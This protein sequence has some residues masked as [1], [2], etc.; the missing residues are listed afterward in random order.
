M[1]V[2]MRARRI[3]RAGRWLVVVAVAT[4]ASC[5]VNHV[6]FRPRERAE[7]ESPDGHPAA[8]YVLG[9]AAHPL[10]EVRVWSRGATRDDA[11]GSIAVH[12]GFEVENHSSEPLAIDLASTRLT[13][14]RAGDAT[15]EPIGAPEFEGRPTTAPGEVGVLE[16]LFRLPESV[17][18]PDRIGSFDVAWSVRIAADEARHQVTPFRRVR[19]GPA[20]YGPAWH[21]PG[22][23]GPSRFGPSWYGPSWCGP[24]WYGGHWHAGYHHGCHP[25]A[26]VLWP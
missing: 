18:S 5:A 6:D 23:Y 11:R 20:W 17:A 4:C 2:A 10:G 15:L 24:S 14:V 9:D 16:L 3:P 12:V 19:H 1:I 25:F 26:V 21:G 13:A 22:W 7:A 8:L